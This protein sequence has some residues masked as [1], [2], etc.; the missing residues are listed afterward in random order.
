M[1]DKKHWYDGLI[2]DKFIAP[3]Q[4]KIYGIIKIIIPKE[5]SVVDVG[6]GTGRLSFKLAEH[7]NK[8]VGID[9]SSK[10]IKVANSRLRKTDYKN[11]Y[12]VHGDGSNFNEDSIF[13]FAVI[14]YVIH[15]MP[16]SERS[17]L[18]TQIKARVKKI[19]ISDYLTPT[20]KNLWG[21]ANIVVEYFAGKDHYNNFR[22]YVNN[23][24]LKQIVLNAQLNIIKEI[25]NRSK[26][27]HL[28]ILE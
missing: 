11:L 19:I 24:G 9:L 20:P 6:C 15:E 5:S 25:K 28:I 22:N 12:F 7:C 18:L 26:T 2:Y 8:V 14:S 3:N 27:S 4:D 10:N 16:E 23:G 13:D 17:R 21:S 1:I